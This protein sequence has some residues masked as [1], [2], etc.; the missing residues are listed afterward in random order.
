MKCVTQNEI[1]DS[2]L[3]S[4]KNNLGKGFESYKNHVYRVYNFA[5][6]NITANQDIQALSIAS[7]FHDLGIWTN[8]TFDYIQPS[9]DLAKKYCLENSITQGMTLEIVTMIEEHHK[10][11]TVKHARLAELFRQAD[12]TDLTWGLIYR[13][14][15]RKN[16]V[17]IK[18]TFPNKGFHLNLCKLFI[19]NLL[20]NPLKPLPMYKW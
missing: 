6:T 5:I 19:K 13:G 15:G 1:I 20:V 17:K 3:N 2:I 11:S 7:A 8:N 14:A 12:L 10:L 18:E 16:I 9:I 4:F